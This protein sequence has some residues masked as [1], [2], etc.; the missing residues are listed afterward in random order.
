MITYITKMPRRA[1]CSKKKRTTSA[2]K[3]TGDHDGAEMSLMPKRSIC[4]APMPV[5]MPVCPRPPARWL[6]NP[7][8]EAVL[9]TRELYIRRRSATAPAARLGSGSVLCLPT[10]LR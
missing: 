1:G 10:V 5:P 7:L 4:W 6:M 9:I 2:K 8:S 3:E